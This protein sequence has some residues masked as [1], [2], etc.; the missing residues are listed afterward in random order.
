MKKISKKLIIGVIALIMVAITGCNNGNKNGTSETGNKSSQSVDAKEK[1]V[2]DSS[3]TD[4]SSNKTNTTTD[5][6]RLVPNI[7]KNLD[8]KIKL[9]AVKIR[10][11][12]DLEGLPIS[13][14]QTDILKDSNMKNFK[15]ETKICRLGTSYF[16]DDE[17][18]YFD[19][20]SFDGEFFLELTEDGKVVNRFKEEDLDK[21]KIKG[22]SISYSAE[23]TNYV[24]FYKNIRVGYTRKAIEG[25]L[26]KGYDVKMPLSIKN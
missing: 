3:K 22:I 10:C 19:G 26:G 14:K 24:V 18:Y 23:S 1:A 2:N 8:D 9:T 20:I 17:N 13:G 5:Q 6:D 25:I 15:E 11:N 16:H 4:N 12:S 21:Y 7:E